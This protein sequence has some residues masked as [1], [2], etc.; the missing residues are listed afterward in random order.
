[1]K[2]QALTIFLS[3]AV[4]LTASMALIGCKPQVHLKIKNLLHN[5]RN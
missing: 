1:M 4:V 2:K 5:L 3:V